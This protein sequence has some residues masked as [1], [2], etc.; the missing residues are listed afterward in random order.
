[1]FTIVAAAAGVAGSATVA[2]GNRW[3][4]GSSRVKNRL[5]TEKATEQQKEGKKQV[6]HL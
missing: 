6:R 3:W 1:M 5:W 4:A 2:R